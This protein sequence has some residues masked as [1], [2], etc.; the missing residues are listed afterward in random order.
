M[1]VKIRTRGYWVRSANATSA[2]SSPP[3]TK[4][5]LSIIY[6]KI[7]TR[8]TC[9]SFFRTRKTRPNDPCPRTLRR[10][11]CDGWA[12]SHP[13]LVTSLTSISCDELFDVAS[14]VSVVSSSWFSLWRLKA[15]TIN[16]FSLSELWTLD[17]KMLTAAARCGGS[18]GRASFKRAQVGETL[19]TWVRIPAAA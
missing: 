13:S 11:K 9:P 6:W 19:L 16:T 4:K 1:S 18:V 10:S 8:L 3:R 14:S 12:F 2:L 15:K 17:I 5:K 7:L